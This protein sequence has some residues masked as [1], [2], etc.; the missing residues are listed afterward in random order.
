MHRRA[1]PGPPFSLSMTL[2]SVFR[3]KSV[4]AAAAFCCVLL[5]CLLLLQGLLRLSPCP[6]LMPDVTYSRVILDRNG[7]LLRMG[8]TADHKYRLRTRLEDIPPEAVAGVIR[9]EDRYF[10]HHP[11]VNVLSLLR[12]GCT[13]LT[14]GRTMGGSTITM[15]VARLSAGLRTGSLRDKLRQIWL[16]LRLEAHYSKAGIL[17]AYFNLAPY[18]GNVE[19]LGAAA[20][21]YF[22]KN[23]AELTADES[24]ALMLVPQNPGRRNPAAAGSDFYRAAQRLIR[25]WYGRENAPLRVHTPADMPFR[26]PHLAAEFLAEPGAPDIVRTAVDPRLQRLLER[27]LTDFAAHGSPSGLHNACALL[28][29]WPTMEVRALAG[30]ADFFNTAISGQIDG[31]LARRSPGSTLKPFI[32]ALALDQ[33]L[34]HPMTLLKDLPKSFAGY[35]PGN[36]DGEFRGP[37]PACEALRLS[38]NVPAITLASELRDPDLYDF[39]RACHVD[40]ARDR[41]HYGL[42]LVL[43]GAEVTPR[44]LAALYCMLA[45]KG[46]WKPLRLTLE[47]AQDAGLAMLSPEAGFITLDMLVSGASDEKLPSRDGK[48]I[49]VRA[50]TGTSNGFR[51]A[52]TA[53]VVGPYVLVVWVGNFNNEAH[54]L[55]VGGRTAKP[56]FLAMARSLA[57]GEAMTDTLANPPRGSRAIRIPVC[58]ATG[59]LD[60]SLCR[61]TTE[62]WFIPGVSPIAPTGILRKILIDKETGLR[63]CTP[64]EGRTKEVPW[65][66]WPSDLESMFRRAG[67]NK[68]APPHYLPE[69]RGGE[70]V[71]DGPAPTIELP[72]AGITYSLK[73]GGTVPLLANA[74]SG[75]EKLFWFAGSRF[76][77]TS[78]PGSVL[79]FAPRDTLTPLRVVDSAGRTARRTLR[80]APLP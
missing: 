67:I 80:V 4:R 3:R 76:I 25:S 71:S 44:E 18:G 29:H 48:I 59:D 51:D 14:G 9:Y 62:T 11:G 38:R 22:R 56:L 74:A 13:M 72:K 20:Y 37:L 58:T 52:W 7:G 57:A 39:L 77:G 30:S 41:D 53:G 55:F 35:T 65:E 32:Y 19:G 16:A 61:N 5:L 50:K 26:C 2:Q 73:A 33:G 28:V 68:P 60:I 64:Q 42:S 78:R 34:I 17:E 45:N 15:Q 43:G 23:A 47:E 31:T 79:L 12:A 6:P 8:L 69:C 63:A 24:L 70:S 36:F 1:L 46:I 75:T 66:F 10:W 27:H 49:P 40:F 54:P 21:V